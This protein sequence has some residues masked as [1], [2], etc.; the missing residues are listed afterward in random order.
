M[1]GLSG[2]LGLRCRHG[3]SKSGKERRPGGA[4][5]L[6]AENMD[7]TENN[8]KIKIEALRRTYV[9]RKLIG[10]NKLDDRPLNLQQNL[11]IGCCWVR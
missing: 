3:A 6:S 4:V 9:G 7:G 10:E 1:S 8:G 5:N 11:V 2:C